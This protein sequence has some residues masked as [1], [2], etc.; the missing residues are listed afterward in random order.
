MLPL[1]EK[2]KQKV[3]SAHGCTTESAL[4]FEAMCAN[5]WGGAAAGD[6]TGPGVIPMGRGA[7]LRLRVQCRI[8]PHGDAQKV[9]P[10]A[11]HPS[12]S[13]CIL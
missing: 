2:I 9:D 6:E 7:R 12:G 1:A 11:A 13:A 4:F 8:D 10:K 5:A 3:P